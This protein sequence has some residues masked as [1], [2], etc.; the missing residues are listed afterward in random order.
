MRRV[1]GLAVLLAALP[2][3]AQ[4][5]DGSHIFQLQCKGCHGGKPG[6]PAPPLAGVFGSRIAS[7]PDFAYSAGIKARTGVWDATS[8]DAF[9]TA[10]SKFVP[11]TAMPKP[12]G[13]TTQ[14]DRAAVIDY[15]KTLH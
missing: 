7:K 3:T 5:A 11:G 8:L 10:P 12:P 14:K 9:L 4:A 2:A 13:L 15:L 6:D 1:I